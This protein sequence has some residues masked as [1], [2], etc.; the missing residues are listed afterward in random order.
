ML[1]EEIL[2]LLAALAQARVVVG[3]E[4]AALGDDLERGADVD[5]VAQSAPTESWKS[6]V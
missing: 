6:V 3:E 5:Q 1:F 2:G 4:R